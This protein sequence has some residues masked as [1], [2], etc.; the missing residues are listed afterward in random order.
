MVKIKKGVSKSVILIS[1]LLISTFVISIYLVSAQGT[2]ASSIVNSIRSGVSS[3]FS[4][5]LMG[6]GFSEGIAKVLMTILIFM[7]IWS[8]SE[9]APIIS[10]SGNWIRLVFVL[11]ITFLSTAFL[12]PDEIYIMM[13]SYRGVGFAIGIIIPFLIMI[14][15][16]IALAAGGK[17]GGRNIR[18]VD[19]LFKRVLAVFLWLIFTVYL[20]YR[21]YTAQMPTSGGDAYTLLIWV[22]VAVS[23]FMTIFVWYIFIFIQRQ[24]MKVQVEQMGN[25]YDLAVEL[26]D[27][28]ARSAQRL[29]NS[30]TMSSRFSRWWN[31]P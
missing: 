25:K 2:D 23:A 16:T 9:Y 3:F 17:T 18:P 24:L 22:L 8:V 21:S 20:A 11:I 1:L 6:A 4:N 28:Q 13:M 29:A 12:T 19:V 7:I 5:W 31:G 15:F 14:L 27:T 10:D 26:T 30:R